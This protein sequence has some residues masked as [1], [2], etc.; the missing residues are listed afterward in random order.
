MCVVL[1]LISYGQDELGYESEREVAK[2][3]KNS[4]VWL[5]D[6]HKLNCSD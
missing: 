1:N 2:V 6:I 5:S 3:G 4:S